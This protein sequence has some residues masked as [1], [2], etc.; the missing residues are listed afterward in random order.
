[1][2]APSETDDAIAIDR[3]Q[4]AYADAVNTR[5]WPALH[6]IFLPDASLSL[7]LVTRPAMSFSGPDAIGG[8]I[9]PAIERFA[10]FQFVILNSHVDLWPGGDHDAATARLFMC[11]LRATR[12]SPP[13]D[14]AEPGEP[15][16]RDDAFGLYRDRYERTPDGWRIA[17]RRYRSMARFP[18]GDVFPLPT[19]LA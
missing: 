16:A 2:T 10:F 19:D 18:S 3:L 9:G 8:F 7:D 5:D 1:V 13:A 6:G 12:A 15:A 11:E 14:P 17:A 4:R